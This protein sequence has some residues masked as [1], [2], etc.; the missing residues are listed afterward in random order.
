MS[1]YEKDAQNPT[2]TLN[3]GVLVAANE[4]TLERAGNQRW[5][6]VNKSP[7]VVWDVVKEFWME[8]GFIIKLD[9]PE[10][11]VMETDWAENRANIPS[12]FIRNTIGSIFASIYSTGDRGVQEVYTSTKQESTVWQPRQSDPEL[13]AEFLRRLVVRFS[14][15]EQRAKALL[16]S[17]KVSATAPIEEKAVLQKDGAVAQS[18]VVNESFERSW[19]RVGL[20]LE[21][22]GFTVED[23]DRTNGVFFVRYVRPEDENTTPANKKG[24][25]SKWFGSSDA[26]VKVEFA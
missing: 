14:A 26:K 5:L 18:L 13:E 12:D 8:H 23:R 10:V 15:S 20:A 24:L 16:P 2:N 9:Q 17:N 6:V 19:R 1:E 21:Q 7:D 22:V 4:V 25:F 11:G 3:S